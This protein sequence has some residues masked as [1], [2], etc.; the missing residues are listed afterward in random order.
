VSRERN[1]AAKLIQGKLRLDIRKGRQMK[2]A[3][4]FS[5]VSALALAF[6]LALTDLGEAAGKGKPGGGTTNVNPVIVYVAVSSSGPYNELAVANADGSNQ[7]ALLSSDQVGYFFPAWSPDFNLSEPGFQGSVVFEQWSG[8]VAAPFI[9]LKIIDVTV[10]SSGLEIGTLQELVRNA[11]APAWSRQ[12][13]KIAYV[14][15]QEGEKGIHIFDLTTGTDTLLIPALDTQDAGWPAWKP[16]GTQLA[17][18]WYDENQGVQEVRIRDLVYGDDFPLVS[19]I[20]ASALDWSPSGTYIAFPGVGAMRIVNATN[21][22]M[23][24]LPDTTW[25]QSPT[26]TPDENRLAFMNRNG[27]S[28]AGKRKIVVRDLTTQVE[29]VIVER[30]G[31]HLYEPDWRR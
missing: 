11:S 14:S 16:N 10:T 4:L 3:F 28:G 27:R 15:H 7:T 25:A 5:V 26:W 8:S 13:D 21:G 12:G 1:K 31:F 9:V 2:K 17:Y 6:V 29:T 23:E 19:D 22:D 30:N 20:G 18:T 24:T